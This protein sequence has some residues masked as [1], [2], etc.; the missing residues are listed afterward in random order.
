ML[1]QAQGPD[2]G[3]SGQHRQLPVTLPVP[4]P[5]RQMVGKPGWPRKE[6]AG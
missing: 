1:A 6:L 5:A 3:V 4:Q 2:T